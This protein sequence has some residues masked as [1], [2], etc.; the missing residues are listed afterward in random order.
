[1]PYALIGSD[2]ESPI[3][4]DKACTFMLKEKLFKRMK[5]RGKK[6]KGESAVK[7]TKIKGLEKAEA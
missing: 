6:R 4:I 5:K 1:L 3:L 7:R 2:E